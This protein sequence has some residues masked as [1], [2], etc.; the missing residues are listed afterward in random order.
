MSKTL[1]FSIGYPIIPDPKVRDRRMEVTVTYKKNPFSEK[2][3]ITNLELRV[4][5]QEIPWN[6]LSQNEKHLVSEDAQIWVD[7]QERDGPLPEE[8]PFVGFI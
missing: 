7:L 1:K 6:S 2:A 8:C 5:N 3:T 4:D